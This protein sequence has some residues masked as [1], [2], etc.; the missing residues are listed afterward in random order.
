M[1]LDSWKKNELYREVDV[2]QKCL[3][4]RWVCN[5]KSTPEGTIPNARLVARGFEEFIAN[6]QKDSL[7]CAHEPLKLIIAIKAQRQWELHAM[8]I[9]TPF[10]QGQNMD[11]EVYVVPPKEANSNGI[12]LL[13]KWVYGLS[14]ASLYWYKRVKS[15]MLEHGGSISKLDPTVFYWC[16]D[17][18]GQ[19]MD[20]EVYVVPPKEANSNGIWLLNKWVY[21]LSDASLYWYKRVKSVMLEHGGSISKLD[22]TVFYW[23][24]DTQGQNMDREVYVVPP[25]EANSNGIW[26]FNKWPE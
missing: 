15:A 26:L 20:R 24:D 8:D 13:N 11:R 9:K 7:T 5:L 23:C 6:I 16:D 14:D 22:P 17:T 21:G 18:Q 12:W 1:E 4:I 10:L 2:G 25:K 3:S 19:N